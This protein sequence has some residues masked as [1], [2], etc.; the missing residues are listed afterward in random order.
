MKNTTKQALKILAGIIAF[1]LI[2]S[3]L[4][5]TNAFLGNPI[6]AML[7]NNAIKQYVN[8]NYFHL[9][10]EVDKAKY[11]FKTTGYMAMAE[12]KTSIDTKFA[13]YYS[14]GKVQRDD[15]KDYVLGMYNTMQRLSTEYSKLAKE[16][17]N[18]LGYENNT[19]T[20]MVDKDQY[21]NSNTGLELDMK[22]DKSLPVRTEVTIGLDSID[23]SLEGIAKVLIDAHKAFVDNGCKFS[24]YGLYA[25]TEGTS[26]LVYGVTPAD[27]EGGNLVSLLEKAMENEGAGGI[28]I[29]IKEVDK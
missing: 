22:F 14:Q 28:G 18:E 19:T 25:E 2:G 16:I 13:I 24:L 21:V 23:S 11:S 1:V 3:M 9:D 4:Y 15:Y 17:I 29:Q 26:V 27:I 12:S 10:L 5:I 8:Q 20:V 6:S 7:A